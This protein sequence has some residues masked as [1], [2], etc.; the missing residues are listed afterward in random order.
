MIRTFNK[1][2]NRGECLI[3]GGDMK[4][5]VCPFCK[6]EVWEMTNKGQ[7]YQVYCAKRNKGCGVCGPFGDSPAEALDGFRAMSIHEVKG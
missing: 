7:G 4:K 3:C 2:V 6:K 5:A 1:S